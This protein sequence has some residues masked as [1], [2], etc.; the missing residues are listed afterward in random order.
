LHNEDE[1]KRLGLKIG[2]T[3]ILE[4]AGDII[5]KVVEVLTNLRTGREKD[6]DMQRYCDERGIPV[7]KE[8]VGDQDSVA[9]YTNNTELLEVKVQKFKH[10]VSK[11]AMNIDGMGPRIVEK[12]L[13][14]GFISELADLYRLPKEQILELEGF[15]EKSVENLLRCSRKKAENLCYQNLFS[16]LAF[17]TWERRDRRTLGK[18]IWKRLINYKK[19]H[20]NN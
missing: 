7:H 5:P 13:E 11:K 9:W 4:K 14:E 16:G 1:I 12:F 10:F 15:K 3:I 20:M 19:L 6:F 17:D 18:R 2:D 8:R